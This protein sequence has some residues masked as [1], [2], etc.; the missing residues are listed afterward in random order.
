MALFAHRGQQFMAALSLP[1]PSDPGCAGT[2][3]LWWSK[4]C[5]AG[6]QLRLLPRQRQG[7][8]AH[9]DCPLLLGLG[10]RGCVPGY[11]ELQ[12]KHTD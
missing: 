6:S 9:T 4:L 10:K 11:K 3:Q 8:S 2:V 1:L 12:N 5:R 7:Y